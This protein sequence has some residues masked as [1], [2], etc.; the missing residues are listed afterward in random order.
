MAEVIRISI[1]TE[2]SQLIPCEVLKSSILRRT[3][4][5]VEFSH[6]WTPSQGWHPLM[7]RLKHGTK[8]SGW[9][10]AVAE[11][12]G[13]TG[14]AIYLDA[15][16]IVLADIVELW[17]SLPAGKAFAAVINAVGIF[18]KKTPEPN[19]VQTSVMVMDCSHPVWDSAARCLAAVASGGRTYRELMQAAFVSRENIHDL[20]PEWNLFG[21]E[22]AG[23]NLIHYSHVGSQPWRNKRHPAAA[24]WQCELSAA[25]A[26]GHLGLETL[27]EEC[28]AG[29]V[30]GIYYKRLK[31]RR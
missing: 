19:H 1:G 16:Q 8:F 26:A 15:D 6:S 29:H 20:P 24:L 10:W 4:R 14:K 12:Y 28:A 21:V 30:D 22:C 27:R 2:P 9:R 5:P 3:S 18:G 25:I 7:P 31:E 13:R 23:A 11:N 17:D